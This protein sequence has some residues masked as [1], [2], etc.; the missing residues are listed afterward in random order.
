MESLHANAGGTG[1]ALTGNEVANR[2]I[3]GA[4]DDT[5]VGGGGNDT[6]I[7]GAGTAVFRFLGGFGA[8]TIADFGNGANGSQ[9]LPDLSGLGVTAAT[10]AGAVTLSGTTS[11][12]IRV[13]VSVG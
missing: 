13:D 2:I 12:L 6:L 9:D 10:F 5:L 3:G 1:L 7:G 8:A 11:A 4:G